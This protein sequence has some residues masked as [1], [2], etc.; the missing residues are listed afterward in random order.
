MRDLRVFTS[1]KRDIRNRGENVCTG[2]RKQPA[3][4]PTGG[5]EEAK[6][7]EQGKEDKA[8]DGTKME[9]STNLF[10]HAHAII[11]SRVKTR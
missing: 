5:V 6:W 7:K 10:E 9:V 8:L 3:K 4:Q 2:K 11:A 1:W